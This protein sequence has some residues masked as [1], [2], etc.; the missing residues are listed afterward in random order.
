MSNQSTTHNQLIQNE[1]TKQADAYS[2]N[3]TIIDPKWAQRLVE[4]SAP[5]ATDHVL[6]IATGP[7]YVALAFA[8]KGCEVVGIDLTDAPLAIATKNRDE[9]A[10]TN[11]QFEKAD[12]NQLP[13]DDASFDIIVCRFAFH[14]M[15]NP[16]AVLGEMV[17]VCRVGGK[18][19]VEDL[20]S[21]EVPARGDYQD[22]WERLRDPSHTDAL[23]LT[24][25]L[26]LFTNVEVEI[27]NVQTE[28][29]PQVIE[30]WLSNSQ[31]PP[32]VT[33]EVRDLLRSDE[34]SG[35]S[36]MHVYTNEADEFC[37]DH[38]VHTVVGIKR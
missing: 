2:S 17:R 10:L 16:A 37:F 6:D 25:L 19:A 21:S 5:R 32:S 20:C 35:L 36:G 1:F 8:A 14:H 26:E 3:P 38:R 9:R 24:E 34:A 11:V 29:R 12:A 30:E 18:I 7:G 31:T 15:P 13:F 28:H 27:E 4:N 33:E 22:R 23:S